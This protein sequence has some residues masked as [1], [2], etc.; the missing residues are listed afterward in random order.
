MDE[1]TTNYVVF[2]DFPNHPNY[3]PRLKNVTLTSGYT[4]FED[5]RKILAIL[6][7][8]KP[9]DVRILSVDFRGDNRK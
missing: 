1:I 4:E 7:G 8:L 5:I 2:H 9:E 6:V 3:K